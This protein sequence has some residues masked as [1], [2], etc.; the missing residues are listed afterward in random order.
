VTKAGRPIRAFALV[1]LSWTVCRI[2]ATAT[3]PIGWSAAPSPDRRLYQRL[4]FD[5]PLSA[6]VERRI[7]TQD[8]P[9]TRFATHP[10]D[11][12]HVIIPPSPSEQRAVAY[13]N[14]FDAANDR[15]AAFERSVQQRQV[16]ASGSRLEPVPF[17]TRGSSRWSMDAWTLMRNGGSQNSLAS[18]GQLGASQAGM[19]LQ[20]DL[21][22]GRDKR[23]ALYSR[24]SSALD[25]PHAPEAALG[26]SYRPRRNM[27]FDISV[28]R[29]VPLGHGAR[30]A[31]ALVGTTGF[32]PA[33]MPLGLQGEG[34]AQAGFVGVKS[35]DAF[36]DGKISLGKSMLGDRVA[37]GLSAS[38]GAQPHLSRLDIGPHI[39]MRFSTGKI[40]SRLA[41]EWRQRITGRAQP[42]SG[43]AIILAAGF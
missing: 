36:V 24:L 40:Q 19:R 26:I 20:Y 29:R 32:G 23:V 15:Y 7:H 3:L 38:G 41:A 25:S 2:A 5:I 16:P 10:K 34:Y 11:H 28:E 4:T 13:A 42:G 27:P 35:E 9:A 18:Y 30:N 21:T 12:L 43:P 8:R 1:I 17:S 37:I 6:S 14:S 22:P 31:F 39:Q 33:R